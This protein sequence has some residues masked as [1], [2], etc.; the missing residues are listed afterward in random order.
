M[1]GHMLFKRLDKYFCYNTNI[2]GGGNE[3]SLPC[4]LGCRREGYI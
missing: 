3:N 1:L 4:M 2:K